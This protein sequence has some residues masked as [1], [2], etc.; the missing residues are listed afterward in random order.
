MVFLVIFFSVLLISSIFG[1]VEG[2]RERDAKTLITATITFITSAVALFLLY[3]LHV[4]GNTDITTYEFSSTQYDWYVVENVEP[5]LAVVD[6]EATIQYDTTY[7]LMVSGEERA[8]SIASEPG[9][10]VTSKVIDKRI[11]K[12]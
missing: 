5:K 2:F 3:D 11:Q 10:K 6:G 4:K 1:I 7:V 8:L 9:K 12:N